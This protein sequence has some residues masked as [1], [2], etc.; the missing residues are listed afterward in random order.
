MK[1]DF[2]KIYQR[3]GTS[4]FKWDKNKDFFGKDDIISLWVADMD[5]PTSPLIQKAIIDR[6]KH[7]LFG[8]TFRDDDYFAA[9]INWQKNQ[10]NWDINRQ[11][12]LNSTSVV[13]SINMI[14]RA[15]TQPQDDI[16][17]LSPV[18]S[19]F[20]AT[21]DST[22]RNIIS[23]PLLNNNERF[24]ID[25]VDL[26]KKLALGIK[27]LV[28]CSPHNPVGRVWTYDEL[29][30]I[31]ELCCQ[32]NTMII[33]DEIHSDLIYPPHKHTP[34]ASISKEISHLTITCLSPGKSFNLSGLSISFIVAENP[35]L[36]DKIKNIF[37]AYHLMA[38]NIF[39]IT[40]CHT[41]F[42]QGLPW[43]QEVLIHLKNNRDY[44]YN[45]IKEIPQ[46]KM[47]LPEGTYLAWL[48][49]RAL[50]LNQ[51]ELQC[52]LINV[53]QLGLDN[54]TKFGLEGNG[55]MRFNFAIALPLLQKALQQLKSAIDKLVDA[56]LDL[57]KLITNFS[58]LQDCD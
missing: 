5:L 9:F 28:F 31:G 34:L 2:N 50:K 54:G 6:A 13:V 19:Q 23:S 30:K 3:R 36:R 7:P 38:A 18:Y 24:E 22:Q 29:K 51:K 48:D 52:F 26:E 45:F 56:H 43:L 35:R 14:I 27:I 15:F 49:F 32:Y 42:T 16:L 44:L 39:G 20:A 11:W 4:C 33:S 47:F 8:Y 58:D 21:I 25:F 12:I 37:M 55:F 40:A 53:A 10:N 46:I 17:I 1:T 41:A 57:S